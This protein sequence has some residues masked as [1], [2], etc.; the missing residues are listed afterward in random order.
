MDDLISALEGNCSQVQ[1]ARIEKLLDQRF[2]VGFEDENVSGK[3]LALAVLYCMAQEDLTSP[4]FF[5]GMDELNKAS[6]LDVI[7]Q[8]H[9]FG[10]NREKEIDTILSHLSYEIRSLGMLSERYLKLACRL[11]ELGTDMAPI[12]LHTRLVENLDVEEAIKYRIKT[13]EKERQFWEEVT[14][15]STGL[16]PEVSSANQNISML[17]ARLEQYESEIQRINEEW[18]EIK[19]VLGKQTFS[20]LMSSKYKQV[21]ADISSPPNCISDPSEFQDIRLNELNKMLEDVLKL[22]PYSV[23]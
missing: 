2:K 21:A 17:E 14:E 3:D 5:D 13:M 10:D 18:G 22:Y 7:E 11:G 1:T 16:E 9:D 19:K 20:H 6:P 8:N 4:S 12:D 23:G 15:P